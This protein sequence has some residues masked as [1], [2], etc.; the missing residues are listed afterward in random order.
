MKIDAALR[1]DVTKHLWWP[2]HFDDL[3]ERLTNSKYGSYVLY[4]IV[5]VCG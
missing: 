2:N 1:I 5:R 3:G 4:C